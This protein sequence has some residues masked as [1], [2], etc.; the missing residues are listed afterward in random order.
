MFKIFTTIPLIINLYISP[1]CH[2]E[3]KALRKSTKQAYIFH[4]HDIFDS[5]CTPLVLEKSKVA[6][7]SFADD[8]V[9]LS[10][11][12]EGLQNSL[13]NLEKILLW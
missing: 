9:I 3:S 12:S 10:N 1:L 2:R 13:N 7:R 6:S 8:L 4:L 5:T 11:T